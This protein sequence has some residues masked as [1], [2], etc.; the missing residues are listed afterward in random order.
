VERVDTVIVG[1]GPAGSATALLLARA[2][3][4]VLLLDRRDFPRAKACG[5]CLSAGATR[6]LHEL[7]VLPRVEAE[8]PAFLTGWRII[9]PGGREFASGFESLAIDGPH[10]GTALALPRERLDWILLDAARRA[11]AEVRTGVRVADL[12]HDA[13]GGVIGVRALAAG[14]QTRVIRSRLVVG[15]DG[16]RSTVARKLNLVRRLPRLRKVSLTAHL[17]GVQDLGDWGEMHLIDGACVG[18]APVYSALPNGAPPLSN[19]TLVVDGDRFAR[20]I[21]RAGTTPFFQ[22]MLRRFPQ[23]RDRIPSFT[24]LDDAGAEGSGR[25]PPSRIALLASGP[26]DWPTRAITA[27]GAALVGDAAGYYDPFTGQGIYQ[28]LAGAI[29][30]A[31]E[32]DAALRTN[33]QPVPPL[34]GYAR[35]HRQLI[36]GGRRVQRLIE[37]VIA[38]PA[39]AD[40]LIARLGHSPRA[41]ATLLAV[42]GD[43]W[44][45]RSLLNPCVAMDLV[46]KRTRSEI[47]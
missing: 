17:S 24:R 21:A 5:D 37:T 38:R 22:M 12:I 16:L 39:L 6:I 31:E 41:A 40:Q 33:H 20:Q 1:A 15:A 44:P 45:A 30:L 8:R 10:A 34:R 29:I 7:G 46:R 9:S 35:R 14:D 36:R 18:L 42:T 11:G 2:G 43:L 47:R 27:A 19:L 28:G 25:E 32:A 3:H 13:Q 26:F 23:L 4:R